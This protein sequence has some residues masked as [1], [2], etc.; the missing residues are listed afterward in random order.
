LRIKPQEGPQT[1]FF[2]SP[3]DIV[4]YGGAAG[5]GKSWAL[6]VE[7]LR[8]ILYGVKNFTNVI[9]RRTSPEITNP[10]GLWDESFKL[11]APLGFKPN[12]TMLS[13]YD[14]KSGNE[15]KLSHM[16]Y[17]KDLASWW[18]AQVCLI[19]FD[20]LN[21]FTRRQFFEML[22]RNRSTCGV[23]PYMRA[24]CNPDPD[25]WVLELIDW[26]IEGDKTSVEYG[27]PILDRS[28]KIR[29][30]AVI[31]DKLAW[32][33]TKQALLDKF[34][35]CLP[36]SITFIPAK[37]EDNKILMDGDPSYAAKL[38]ALPY[39]RKMALRY[40]NWRIRQEGVLFKRKW[41]KYI[42]PDQAPDYIRAAVG[43][44][45][46][47][48]D[49][50]LNDEQGI[51]SAGKGRNAM[52]YVTGDYSGKYTPAGW[53]AQ[54]VKLYEDKLADVVAAEV[55]YGGDMVISN[56]LTI[57]STVN[58]K[59]VTASRGKAVRAEPIAT[60]M[61]NGQIVFV[62]PFPELEAE[63]LSYDPASNGP[64]PNRMDAFVWAITELMEE[65]E[66]AALS[67]IKQLIHEEALEENANRPKR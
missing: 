3:A 59:K 35:K 60:L 40:G 27:L 4:I 29:W 17:E 30:F 58:V 55:N 37:L 50:P 21:T 25:S 10:G 14:P 19:Q 12:E 1:A 24:S 32:A 63:L 39:A 38:E 44:D 65:A 15:I 7:P 56:I 42:E 61:Q 64:S 23:M 20:E 67:Y 31:E 47:G 36:L 8:H 49:G 52:Y 41:F 22:A 57:K 53:G 9:F 13:W 33:S 11:Y 45:P 66:P 51:V 2:E 54:T 5:G 46:S 28:G 62:G 26:W 48:G 6:L 16:Q 18:G 34:P 43:C